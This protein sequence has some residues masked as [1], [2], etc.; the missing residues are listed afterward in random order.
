MTA[1]LKGELHMLYED[2]SALAQQLNDNRGAR[3]LMEAFPKTIRVETD[4]GSALSISFVGGRMAVAQGPGG[5][6]DIIVQTQPLAFAR[7]VRG[8]LDYSHLMAHGTL[9]VTKG[10]VSDMVL[11]NRIL[12]ITKRGAA[13]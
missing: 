9:R 1:N 5:E 2:L 3:S 7:V 8:E 11:L 4:D 6:P 10:K 13:A 12:W